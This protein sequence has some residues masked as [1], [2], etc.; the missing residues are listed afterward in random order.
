VSGFF[1]ERAEYGFERFDD[2][3]AR[4]VG[5]LELQSERER[6]TPRLE[7]EDVV[8]G[9]PA[10]A[11]RLGLLR[12]TTGIITAAALLQTLD[13]SHHFLVVDLSNHL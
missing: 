13:K 6:P 2:F 12:Q 3:F 11:T 8:A 10:A 1:A 4:D 5:A 9:A 7:L